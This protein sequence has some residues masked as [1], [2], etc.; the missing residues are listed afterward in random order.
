[1]IAKQGV[2]DPHYRVKY[3]GLSSMA[4]IYRECSPVAQ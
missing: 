4:N 2:S 1:M 3:A